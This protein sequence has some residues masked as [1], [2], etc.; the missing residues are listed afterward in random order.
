[1]NGAVG[2]LD[3]NPLSLKRFGGNGENLIEILAHG[4]ETSFGS[5]PSSSRSQLPTSSARCSR[6]HGRTRV[7]TRRGSRPSTTLP[8]SESFAQSSA[9][10]IWQCGGGW[11]SKYM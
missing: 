10:R 8:V 1:M 6:S 3:S 2:E 4:G 5:C 11:S 7:S 9:Y